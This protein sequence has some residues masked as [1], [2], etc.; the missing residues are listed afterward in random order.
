MASY[1]NKYDGA[2][3]V[4]NPDQKWGY[5]DWK[6]A[7]AYQ[8][9]STGRISGYG[10]ALD[11]S[12]TYI[13][14]DEWR[15]MCGN[16]VA[17]QP[18][19]TQTTTGGNKPRYA[20][21][22]TGYGWLGEMEGL[23]EVDGGGDDFA[24]V[25]GATCVYLGANNIG[26]YRVYSQANGWLP[27]VDHLNYNDE[28]NGMAGDGSPILAVEIPNNKIKYQVHVKGSGW[29]D[30]MIGNKD[31]GGSNDTYAGDMR[32]PIDGIRITTA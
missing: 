29:Y 31:T 26:K 18:T 16:Y 8:Y 22:A 2:G 30:W 7:I 15:K 20:V 25:M 17:T 23:K 32:T 1:L 9:T 5:G 28:E 21:K 14:A 12:V 24:G 3:F 19:T 4:D 13:T 27:Y 6:N 11:L 10:G